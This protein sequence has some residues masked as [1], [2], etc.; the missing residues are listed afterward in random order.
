MNKNQIGFDDIPG[1]WAFVIAIVVT[2]FFFLIREFQTWNELKR[3]HSTKKGKGVILGWIL[4]TGF[5]IS[6]ALLF[7]PRARGDEYHT[8]IFMGLDATFS[9]SPQC[10]EGEY[11]DRITSNGGIRQPVGNGIF[12]S[13]F[14]VGYL[15][16]SCAFEED[17]NSFDAFGAGL[18]IPMWRF[19]VLAGVDYLSKD[20]TLLYTRNVVYKLFESRDKTFKFNVK[21]T[22][23]N[24]D[25]TEFKHYD[26][27]ALGLELNYRIDWGN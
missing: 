14:Y 13:E 19:T 1:N 11:S 27:K 25:L 24:A 4:F 17:R 22:Q 10:R 8:E 2:F 16:H 21:Y 6:I 12:N 23:H 20:T 15:H 18:S 3:F 9:Q 26:Y 7:P 5:F